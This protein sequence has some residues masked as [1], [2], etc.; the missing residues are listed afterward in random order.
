[1]L[2]C[3]RSEQTLAYL[4][5]HG[6]CR[7][8]AKGTL[9]LTNM[10]IVFIAGVQ[11]AQ[12][13]GLLEP[14][15][16]AASSACLME[17]EAGMLLSLTMELFCLQGWWHLSCHCHISTMTSSTSPSLAPTICQ[18]SS[19]DLSALMRHPWFLSLSLISQIWQ[20]RKWQD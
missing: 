19:P 12:S 17:G 14:L 16:S 2:Q 4:R 13:G 8:S 5:L 9:Y 15:T 7:W 6:L 1:M 20:F 11:D 3:K 10:R 18:A